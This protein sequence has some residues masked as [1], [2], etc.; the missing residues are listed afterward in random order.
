LLVARHEASPARLSERRFSGENL[1]RAAQRFLAQ[2]LVRNGFAT[3]PRAR[4]CATSG[5]AAR[6]K[7]KRSCSS[8]VSIGAPT[9]A[10]DPVAES[11]LSTDTSESPLFTT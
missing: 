4:I 3:P 8:P 7:L 2:S 10:I 9:A 1:V 5:S 11:M 6:A